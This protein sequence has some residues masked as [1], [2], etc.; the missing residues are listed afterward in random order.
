MAAPN[1]V[2]VSTIYG[3]TTGGTVAGNVNINL[4]NCVILKN[5]AGSNKVIKLNTMVVCNRNGILNS[6]V[7]VALRKNT[8][9]TTSN[10]DI[11]MVSTVSVPADATL[12][13][14]SKDI[15]L[16][17]EEDDEI[18]ANASLINALQMIVSYEEIQ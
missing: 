8:S 11:F 17:L 10:T 16:Y 3:K 2:N 1:M 4:S 14:G 5:P 13:V 7:S 15:N 18:R 9:N 6:D 12:V